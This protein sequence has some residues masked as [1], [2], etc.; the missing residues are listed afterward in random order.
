VVLERIRRHRKGV[1]GKIVFCSTLYKFKGKVFNY[2]LRI[3][4]RV[5]GLFSFFRVP[6]WSQYKTIGSQ[7]SVGYGVPLSKIGDYS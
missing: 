2:L 6:K 3:R 7:R 1:D 5:N 4:N